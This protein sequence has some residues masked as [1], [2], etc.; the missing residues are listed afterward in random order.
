MFTAQDFLQAKK[1]KDLVAIAEEKEIDISKT[2]RN[3]CYEEELKLLQVVGN[4]K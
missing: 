2:L 1:R 3:V 4:K